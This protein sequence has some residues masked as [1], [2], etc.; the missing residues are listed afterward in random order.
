MKAIFVALCASVLLAGCGNNTDNYGPNYV[1]PGAA[2]L[3]LNYIALTDC[4]AAKDGSAS[5]DKS[6]PGRIKASGR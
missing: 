4:K 2:S 3:D 6:C 5:A 1:Q